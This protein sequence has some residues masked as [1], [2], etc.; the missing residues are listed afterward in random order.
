MVPNYGKA[1][2]Y[3]LLFNTYVFMQV[4][5][6]INARKVWPHERNVFKGFFKNGIF[7]IVLIMQVGAQ[8]LVIFFGG[9]IF[10]VVQLSW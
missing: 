3:T 1:Q 7:I 5:N 2:H 4:F 6:E 9:S 8:V 10:K